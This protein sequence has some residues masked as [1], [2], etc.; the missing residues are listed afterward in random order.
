MSAAFSKV[1]LVCEGASPR[2]LCHGLGRRVNNLTKPSKV[3]VYPNPADNAIGHC[4]VNEKSLSNAFPLRKAEGL[5]IAK[6]LG[7]VKAQ[8]LL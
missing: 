3:V 5:R 7:L 4:Q 2:S 8:N 6:I 1:S